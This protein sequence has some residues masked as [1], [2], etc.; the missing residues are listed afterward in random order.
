MEFN[1]LKTQSQRNN[2]FGYKIVK[3]ILHQIMLRKIKTPNGVADSDFFLSPS[4]ASGWHNLDKLGPMCR[5][6]RRVFFFKF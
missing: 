6:S 2:F 4:L 5:L 3:T 1:I